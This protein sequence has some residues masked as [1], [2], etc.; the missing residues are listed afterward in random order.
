MHE[1]IE[2]K[3][4]KETIADINFA[5][6]GISDIKVGLG[7]HGDSAIEHNLESAKIKLVRLLELIEAEMA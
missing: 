6:S 3:L 1:E 4:V 7:L 5:M 2:K